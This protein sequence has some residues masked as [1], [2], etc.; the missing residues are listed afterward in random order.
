MKKH[1]LLALACLCG[2]ILPLG[3]SQT[4]RSIQTHRT[5]YQLAQLSPVAYTVV[6]EETVSKPGFPTAMNA[7][8]IRAR[9]LNGDRSV[10]EFMFDGIRSG[11]LYSITRSI[12]IGNSWI[13]THDQ[14]HLK[15]SIRMSAAETV[16][17]YSSFQY[18]PATDCVYDSGGGPTDP[19]LAYIASGHETISGI[20]TVKLVRANSIQWRAPSLGCEIIQYSFNWPDGGYSIH[21]PVKVTLG[22]PDDSLFV[23]SSEFVEQPP[24]KVFAAALLNRQTILNLPKKPVTEASSK[25]LAG[26][27]AV[28]LAHQ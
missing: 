18:T 23:V 26:H 8:Q 5:L 19:R 14:L 16:S 12:N 27:D 7:R 13:R 10:Q 1:L 21:R 24:S 17:R 3:I 25:M 11:K 4:V 28:Y 9:R 20:E 6:L 22:T 2:L 15:T